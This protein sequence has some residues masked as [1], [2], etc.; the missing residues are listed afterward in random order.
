MAFFILAIGMFLILG[1]GLFLLF[2]E[3]RPTTQSREYLQWLKQD[4]AISRSVNQSW[5]EGNWS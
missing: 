5:K 1:V 3:N 4:K 2:L